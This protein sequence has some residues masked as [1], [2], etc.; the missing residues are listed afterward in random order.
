MT[1]SNYR[2]ENVYYRSTAIYNYGIHGKLIITMIGLFPKPRMAELLKSN[3]YQRRSRGS[4]SEG[5]AW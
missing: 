4:E 5:K 2:T 1:N 3:D